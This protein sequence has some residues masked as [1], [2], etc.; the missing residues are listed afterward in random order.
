MQVS[1]RILNLD[2][3]TFL[4]DCSCKKTS[5]NCYQY[6]L[7]RLILEESKFF[8]GFICF[9]CCSVTKLCWTVCN[10]MEHSMPG[11]PVL[12]Y[13]PEF[14]QTCVHWVS[15]AIQPSYPLS[16]PSSPLNLSQHQGLFQVAKILELQLQHLSPSHKAQN[17]LL[18]VIKVS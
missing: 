5:N 16:P 17:H 9:C 3:V 18:L 12:R 11:F 4:Q 8:W 7:N 14:A 10:P 15:D 1:F 6:Y 13:L 2:F